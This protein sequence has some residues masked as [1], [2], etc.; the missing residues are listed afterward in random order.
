MDTAVLDVIRE[1]CTQG[2]AV[3][4]W[5]LLSC[6]L[7]W[8]SSWFTVED[9]SNSCTEE[10][11][12]VGGRPPRF[13]PTRYLDLRQ[14]PVTGPYFTTAAPWIAVLFT[15]LAS[16]DEMADNLHQ[17]LI[18]S[19]PRYLFQ[20]VV[21]R[22]S[23]SHVYFDGFTESGPSRRQ[24]KRIVLLPIAAAL[25]LC[26]RGTSSRRVHGSAPAGPTR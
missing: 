15:H 3:F 19:S 25:Y 11:I 9:I 13:L 5:R 12:F 26:T 23:D 8:V 14:L 1:Y 20:A 10:K 18:T 24:P 6:S 4:H 22:V 21:V 16:F 2:T 7:C 17:F